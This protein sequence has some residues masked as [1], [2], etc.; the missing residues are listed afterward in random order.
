MEDICENKIR[1]LMTINLYR[2]AVF[3]IYYGHWFWAVE[4]TVG[5]MMERQYAPPYEQNKLK[6]AGMGSS[7]VSGSRL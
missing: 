6:E 3:R 5:Y 7:M 1:K 2:E 4:K